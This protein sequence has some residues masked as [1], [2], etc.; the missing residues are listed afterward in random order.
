LTRRVILFARDKYAARFALPE[1]HYYLMRHAFVPEPPP[2]L[3]PSAAFTPHD[4][5]RLF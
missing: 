4:V 2:R 5:L 1:R 3:S